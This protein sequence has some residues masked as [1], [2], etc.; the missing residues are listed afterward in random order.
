MNRAQRVVLFTA[1]ALIVL[2]LLFPP[3][4]HV[5]S[6]GRLPA[7]YGLLFRPPTAEGMY[8]RPA[9]V[10]VG[11]LLAEVA[12]IALAGGAVALALRSPAE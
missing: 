2:A 12:I 6:G 10:N 8:Q 3:F 1:A 9:R 7:G 5:S 11:L 4:E